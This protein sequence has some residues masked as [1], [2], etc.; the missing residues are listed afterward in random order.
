LATIKEPLRICKKY[1]VIASV[2]SK[3]ELVGKF[4]F[5]YFISP[6]LVSYMY[7]GRVVYSNNTSVD[8]TR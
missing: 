7:S 6:A 3:E 4:D 5:E 1:L 8:T 2:L